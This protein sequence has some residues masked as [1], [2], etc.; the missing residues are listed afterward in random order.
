MHQE[1]ARIDAH[2]DVHVGCGVEALKNQITNIDKLGE[3][4]NC[5]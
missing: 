2:Q 3:K 4:K 1:D 5:I